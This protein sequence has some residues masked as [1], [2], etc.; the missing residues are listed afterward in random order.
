MSGILEFIKELFTQLGSGSGSFVDAATAQNGWG[1]KWF[2]LILIWL[3]SGF[4]S[5]EFANSTGMHG[6]KHFWIGLVL[7]VVYPLI[8]LIRKLVIRAKAVSEAKRES[9]RIAAERD[10]IEA[11][12]RRID[13]TPNKDNFSKLKGSSDSSSIKAQFRLELADGS[14]LM[15]AKIL[16]AQDTLS[17]FELESNEGET[18]RVLRMPYAKMA[19]IERV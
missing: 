8:L 19:R 2:I 7:P 1:V 14:V 12:R 13:S 5:Y 6:K 17:A 15:I 4:A 10:Q 11:E 9:Q 16:E 18:P 3:L